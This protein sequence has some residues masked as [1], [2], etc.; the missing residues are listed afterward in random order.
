MQPKNVPQGQRIAATSQDSQYKPD[1]ISQTLVDVSLNA[2]AFRPW[3]IPETQPATSL[4]QVAARGTPQQP[5]HGL[6]TFVP[7]FYVNNGSIPEY[8]PTA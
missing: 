5:I 2:K 3:D 4:A 7:P 1:P 6:N 8:L